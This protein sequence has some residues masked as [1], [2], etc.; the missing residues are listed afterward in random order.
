MRKFITFCFALMAAISINAEE[1][2]IVGDATPIGWAEGA[3]L[4]NPTKMTETDGGGI[5]MDGSPQMWR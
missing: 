3:D 5:R 4:R 2:Y 1:Y